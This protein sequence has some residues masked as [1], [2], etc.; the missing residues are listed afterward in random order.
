M[1]KTILFTVVF[2][3]IAMAN[4]WSQTEAQ[5]T[6]TAPSAK[7]KSEKIKHAEEKSGGAAYSGKGKGGDKDQVGKSEKVKTKSKNKTGKSKK[8]KKKE[9]QEGSDD[10][11]KRHDAGE[12]QEHG[13]QNAPGARD[14]KGENGKTPTTPAPRPRPKAGGVKNPKDTAPKT[15]ESGNQR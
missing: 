3:L 11:R 1:K 2:A 13:G 7:D 4:A 10:K 12:H 9:K 6:Q 5:P 15:K 8:G 14:N